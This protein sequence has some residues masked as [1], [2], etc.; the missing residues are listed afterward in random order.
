MI[1]DN[2]K[3]T[4]RNSTTLLLLLCALLTSCG[5]GSGGQ[6]PPA[7]APTPDPVTYDLIFPGAVSL[8]DAAQISIV[9]VSDTS[10][11]DT[12]TVVSGTSRT[13]A[14]L[15]GSGHW[16]ATDVPLVAG[17]NQLTVEL[18]ENNGNVTEL[19]VANIHSSPI[20]SSP[21]DTQFDSANN[22]VLIL[23][24][25][26]VLSFNLATN[27]LGILSGPGSGEGPGFGF[28]TAFALVGDGAAL[29]SGLRS[30]QRIDPTTGDRSDHIV[31][32]GG[33]GPISTIAYD[34]QL[35]RLFVAGFF[36]D[37]YVADLAA[38]PPILATTIK[39][40]APIG[41]ALGGQTDSVYV[42]STNSIYKVNIFSTDV[43]RID[44]STGDSESIPIDFGGSVTATVGIDYE[45]AAARLLILGRLGAVFS[46]DPI[47]ET[48]GPILPQP[49]TPTEPVTL[50]GLS[51]GD[52]EY[53]SVSR[54]PGELRSIE[55]GT[56]LQS[57][58]ANSQTGDGE[59]PGPMLMGRYD[60]ASDRFIAV[61]D[62]RIIEIDPET[63]SRQHLAD[64]QDLTQFPPPSSFFLASGIALSQDGTRAWISDL[65]NQTVV[66]ADLVSG[67]VHEVSSPD[68]GAGP[69]PDQVSGIAVD[70]QNSVAY[71]SDR[72]A[73][74]IYQLDLASSEREL[75]S[76]LA[77]SLG[78]GQLRSLVFDSTSDRLLLNVAPLTPSSSLAPSIY[79][80]DLGTLDLT[81]LADLTAVDLSFGEATAPGFS[82]LQASLSD[83]GS[84]L[85]IPVSGN[86]DIP[87]AKIDLASGDVSPLGTASTGVPFLAPNAIE[88]SADN[89]LFALDGSGALLIV[90][91]ET[92][93]RAIVSN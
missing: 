53:W 91:P 4:T 83:D 70:L 59:R 54:L 79:A 29:V 34:K 58:E 56:G 14:Q 42:A 82:T 74:R 64:L 55:V 32:P 15:D 67:E 2:L 39:P 1:F 78:P 7:T 40:L 77:S 37:L 35:N 86:A 20:L 93:E 52:N 71:L 50:S 5:G 11:L 18:A 85:Y 8:T 61:A 28:A 65:F 9:G 10:R 68:V 49:I 23:D 47:A 62:I 76:D 16:R 90:D 45:D 75:L 31:L 81:M 73:Q 26:Q 13:A 51:I 63:G 48:S 22:R 6:P 92:G 38:A 87:Y 88:V 84:A 33:S 12:V 57:V 3:I 21:T 72:F 36:D 60:D 19:V 89:R 24:P 46:L 17:G 30:I 25:T 69:L 43:V 27:E 44:A 41:I 66:E 80:L